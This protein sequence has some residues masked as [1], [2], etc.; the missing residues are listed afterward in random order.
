MITRLVTA[1]VGIGVA[2]LLIVACGSNAEQT[3]ASPTTSAQETSGHHEGSAQSRTPAGSQGGH[4]NDDGHPVNG[5]PTGADGSTGNNLTQEYCA[6]NEDP[7]C[8]VGSYVAP[9]AIPN[10]DG[11]NSYVPCEGTICT[12]PNHGAGGPPS[13]DQ[14]PPATDEVPSGDQQPPVDDTPADDGDP[15]N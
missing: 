1:L 4:W 2:P 5:G 10:P 7:G 13:P 3:P 8:P 12:N 9:N 11:S 15:G 6:R 14:A